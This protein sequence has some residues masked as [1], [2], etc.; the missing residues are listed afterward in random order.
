MANEKHLHDGH[1]WT[2][3]T[4]RAYEKLFPYMNP[5]KIWRTLTKLEKAGIIIKGDYNKVKFDRTKWYS[6]T[7]Y[8]MGLFSDID[9]AS[10]D[11]FPYFIL[12]NGDRQN[13]TTIPDSKPYRKPTSR[14][15][16][17]KSVA[18]MATSKQLNFN[19]E[20]HGTTGIDE[21]DNLSDDERTYL[22]RAA[23]YKN[24]K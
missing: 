7:K 8:G 13:E 18:F 1:F 16:R 10:L 15:G 14:K 19:R 17:G 12:K 2:Y 22:E 23:K 4:V 3:N 20:E 11:N 6:I 5:T 9:P 21:N 24:S